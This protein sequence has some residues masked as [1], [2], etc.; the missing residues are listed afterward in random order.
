MQPVP[1]CSAPTCWW[2]IWAMGVA[3]RHGICGVYLF[4]YTSF[5]LCYP[6]RFQNS[7]RPAGERV[8]WCLEPSPLLRLPSRDGSP[9]LTLLSLFSSF[10]FCPTSFWRQ[11]AAFLGAW[12]PLP[13]F[14][15]CFVE[16]SQ[17]SMFF[18]WICGG[19]SGLPILYL[20]HLRTCPPR[21]FSNESALQIRWPKYWSFSFSISLSNEYSG[22]I[23]FRIDWLYLFA[24]QGTLKNLLQHHNSKALILQCSAF[25]MV[26]L[27]HPYM[28]TGKTIVLTRWIF[29]AKWCLCFLISCLGW[30]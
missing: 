8:S 26:Q 19:E 2:L 30:S 23:S 9:S 1:P 29:V 15:I 20:R 13:A 17:P 3:V 22:L 12:C 14:R 21:V 16:F 27:S 6:L 25:F 18:Q 28:T 5:H 4:I 24:V 10:I 7:H 11:W